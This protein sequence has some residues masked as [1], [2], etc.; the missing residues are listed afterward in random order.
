MARVTRQ[1]VPKPNDPPQVVIE[2]E[3]DFGYLNA[4]YFTPLAGGTRCAAS[5]TADPHQKLIEW[6]WMRAHNVAA[7]GGAAGAHGGGVERIFRNAQLAERDVMSWQGFSPNMP[8]NG[9]VVDANYPV[10]PKS[11][12]G[13]WASWCN[14]DAYD[15]T[16]ETVTLDDG[17]QDKWML[18]VDG[19]ICSAYGAVLLSAGKYRIFLVRE[20]FDTL[21]A[22]HNINAEVWVFR[23]DQGGI[24]SR[25]WTR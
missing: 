14:F 23:L 3:K 10:T 18:L 25:R 9:T 6:P 5:Y 20:R 2:W 7:I 15:F 4:A 24:F 1:T 8:L 11:S 21:R 17:L 19:E 16:L 22:A 13:I 12:I